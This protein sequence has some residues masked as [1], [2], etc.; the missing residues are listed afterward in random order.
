MQVNLNKF[1]TLIPILTLFLHILL[2][3]GH[4]VGAIHYCIGGIIIKM[5]QLV[6]G[7]LF[8]SVLDSYEEQE[9]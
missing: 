7:L 6:I 4:G 9:F 3:G 1:L 8:Y 5:N 2:T